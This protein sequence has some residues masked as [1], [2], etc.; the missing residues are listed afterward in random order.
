MTFFSDTPRALA[1][2]PDRKTVYA[3]AFKSGNQTTT[4]FELMVCDGFDP[5]TPCTVRGQ[6]PAWRQSGPMTNFEGKRAPE[7]GLIVKLNRTSGHW[8][9]ETGPQRKGCS[10]FAR[11]GLSPFT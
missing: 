2:S 10:S 1:V 6:H 9:D 7:V 8:E 3:A 5:N 11:P 4:V